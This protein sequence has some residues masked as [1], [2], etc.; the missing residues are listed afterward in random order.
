[1][2]KP[3]VRMKKNWWR[4][5]L[6]VLL[7]AVLLAANL[8]FTAL[9]QQQ[10][11]FIDMTT[12]GRYTLR[13]RMVEILQAA[14]M[15]ADVDIIFCAEADTL[16]ADYNA[17][18]VYIMA[19][20]LE[21]Q[22]ANIHVSTVDATRHPEAVAAYRRTS[23]TTIRWNDVIVA[24]G[25]EYRVYTCKSFFT[26]SSDDENEIVGFNGEQ[27]MCEAILALTAKDLPLAC[28]TIGHGEVLP[29]QGD[30]ETGYFFDC[31]RDAGFRVTAIDLE[32]EDIPAECAVL[33][34]NGPT[35]DYASGRLEDMQYNSPITKIDRFLDQYGTVFYFRNTD[36]GTLPNLEEFLAEWGIGFTVK[37][38]AGT[39]FADTVLSDSASAL[40]GNPDRI[41]GNYGDSSI[42]ADITALSSPPK[43]VFEHAAPLRIL[44]QDA[45]S[46]ANSAGRTVT[47]LFTTDATAQA[48]DKDYSTVKTGAF[49]LATMTSE[50]RI[51]D[52][53]HYTATLFVFST[54]EYHAATYLA[55]HV[56]ANSDVLQSALRGAARTTVSVAEELEFKYYDSLDFTTSYDQEENTILLRDENGKAIWTMNPDTG[57]SERH[58][59]R[60]IRPIEENEKTAW[61]V[62][63]ILLPLLAL[64]VTGTVVT[65]RRKNR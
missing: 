59:I 49:P 63:L 7:I 48:L 46:S 29:T 2:W 9:A 22:V 39:L 13:S 25:T 37:D 12:E 44:W 17:S 24:S 11:L 58:V 6:T 10:N 35:E 50:T 18:L 34:L 57:V 62:A 28:F 54:D 1:M 60:I 47:T 51:V 42:Y 15:Q 61:A 52:S 55:D 14:N 40:G 23:A 27:K 4:S 65:L 26:V 36:A 3:P 45:Y 53:V 43:T 5:A 16:R 20:E 56:Y 30:E 64:A 21:K 32:T 33:I 38:S 19:L 8:A 41:C 31:I